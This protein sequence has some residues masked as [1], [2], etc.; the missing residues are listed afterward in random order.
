MSGTL[1][2]IAFQVSS[3]AITLE[4][5][6]VSDGFSTSSVVTAYRTSPSSSV[7]TGWMARFIEDAGL[8]GT[9]CA[10]RASRPSDHVPR[11]ERIFDEGGRVPTDRTGLPYS[12]WTFDQITFTQVQRGVAW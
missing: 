1:F 8:R 11:A 7:V 6:N 5:M 10:K 2:S 9:D 12:A 4:S 3:D